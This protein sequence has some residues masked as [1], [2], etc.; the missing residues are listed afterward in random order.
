MKNHT[1]MIVSLLLKILINDHSLN[2]S[3]KAINR[4]L[5]TAAPGA[6][7]RSADREELGIIHGMEKGGSSLETCSAWMQ[8]E[9]SLKEETLFYYLSIKSNE[10]KVSEN[11][12][13]LHEQQVI[14]H[15]LRRIFIIN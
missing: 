6:P 5:L 9:H 14:V 4:L 1:E 13:M 11:R 15:F 7:S 3:K 2:P 12:L 8:A 10:H